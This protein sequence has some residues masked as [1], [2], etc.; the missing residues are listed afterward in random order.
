MACEKCTK[1]KEKIKAF[2][3]KTKA[4]MKEKTIGVPNW[5]LFVV[6]PAVLIIG[7]TL[8]L[9]PKKKYK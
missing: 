1:F 3:T 7:G 5:A 4:W 2:W 6:A 8:L 9:L